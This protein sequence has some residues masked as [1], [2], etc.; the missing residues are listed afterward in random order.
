MASSKADSM[1]LVYEQ[2]ETQQLIQKSVS[3]NDV[4]TPLLH[5]RK[6]VFQLNNN[7]P[8]LVDKVNSLGK[9]LSIKDKA[10]LSK[11]SKLN[12][13]YVKKQPYINKNSLVVFCLFKYFCGININVVVLIRDSF[14][15]RNFSNL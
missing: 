13:R 6:R 5:Q 4:R 2:P 14:S 10:T 12:L 7:N 1:T 3:S 15:S 9:P 8:L 11:A